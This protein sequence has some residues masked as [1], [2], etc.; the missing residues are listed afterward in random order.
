MHRDVKLWGVLNLRLVDV[1]RSAKIKADR[2]KKFL[3]IHGAE[4]KKDIWMG[5]IGKGL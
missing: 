1:Y 2:E 5:A 3:G 4:K